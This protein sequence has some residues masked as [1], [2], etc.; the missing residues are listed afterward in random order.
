MTLILIQIQRSLMHTKVWRFVGFASA[1]V[2]LVCY[3]LSSSFNHLF[4]N[5][6]LLKII[7]YTVFSFIICLVILYTNIWSHSRSL[8]FKAH[9]AFLVLTITSVYSFYFDK[10]MNGKPDVYSLISCAAFAI[11]SLS[12]SR[13][14][15]SGFEVDLLYFFLGCLIVLLMKVRL[16]LF[17][18][19]A[20]LSYSLIILRSFFSSTQDIVYSELEHESSVI[21]EVNS[22]QQLA[23]TDIASTMEQL[24][25]YLNTLQQ[26]NLNLVDILL[27]HV[28]EYGDSELMS[29]GPNF[30]INELQPELINYLHE[31]AK[32]MVRAGFEE[33]FSKVYIN[34][35]RK[36]LEE[37][38]INRLFGLQKINLKNEHRQVR[39]VDTVIKRWIT[40]SEIALKILFPF[41]Q[42]LCD[43]VFSGFTSS[44]TR[45]FTEVFH[46][47]TFQLLNFADEVAHGSPSIWRLFKMLAI[48]ETLHYLIPK[49]Q[50]CPDSLVNEAA[51]TV[52]NRLGIAISELFV[53]LNYLIF[54]V[55]AAKK[56]APSD[57]RVHPMT[58]QIISYL[59]SA[60]RSRHTLEQILQEYPKVN[61]G[62]VVKVSFI[63]HM[64]WI[65]DILEKRLKAKSKDY[66]N[67]AL[68]Y[69]FMMNNRSHIEAIIKSWD[70][71]T[72]FGDDWFKKYQAKIQQDFD[73]YQRNSWNKVLEFLK[74]DNNDFVAPD[75]NVTS[76]LLKEKLNLFNKHFDEMYRVQS[77]WS[78]YDKKL[79]E[80]I[81]ISVGNTL[82]P[83]YGIFIGRFRDC[84]GVHAN[85]YIEYGM[86]EIQDRLNNLFLGKR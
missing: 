44:A 31:T 17:I 7:L 41:E 16:Q 49:F 36:C 12:L 35:R 71:E 54:R 33:E 64:Q 81:I 42:R 76:E 72:I 46:G 34:C 22:L 69:L 66:K 30:M 32:L 3:A 55:P 47:T 8:R 19:G 77:T 73:L 43:H 39:Y 6:T 84:F 25:S 60:C 67:P 48:F 24:R 14:T 40:A 27:K 9:T 74:L 21:I 13:Q 28:N 38:L 68:G 58:V 15:Q 59:A 83:V 18:L 45:C 61:N 1:V 23:S 70:L 85:E 4:G 29:F 11:M 62:V 5:W 37:C 86:F 10:V 65:L 63:A 52:Q 57:G 82:L 26:K 20:G 75:D 56:V 79:R 78:V 51:V 53:K 2:G 50:L 80:E